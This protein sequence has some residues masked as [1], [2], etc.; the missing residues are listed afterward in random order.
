MLLMSELVSE[1]LSDKVLKPSSHES[2]G[3]ASRAWIRWGGD[4]LVE[5]ISRKA[6]LE[7]RR[8]ILGISVKAVSWNTYI[9]HLHGLVKFGIERGIV[10][11]VNNPFDDCKVR[12]PKRPKKTVDRIN[13]ER[14]RHVLADMEQEE[15]EW[16]QQAKIHPAWFWRV[17][18]ETFVFTGLRANE[19]ITLRLCDVDI[20]KGLICVAADIAKN[21]E[22]RYVPIVMSY[23]P[24]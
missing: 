19:V 23:F 3:V 1:Y 13:V 8:E 18:Y 2:Y 9:R 15:V 4:C 12:T 14:A 16:G 6:V 5:E 22:E 17:L 21:Y 10:G 24:I 11:L 7:W 20:H